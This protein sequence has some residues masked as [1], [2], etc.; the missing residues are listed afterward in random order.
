MEHHD[1]IKNIKKWIKNRLDMTLSTAWTWS[2]KTLF[3]RSSSCSD[4]RLHNSIFVLQDSSVLLFGC[5]NDSGMRQTYTYGSGSREESKKETRRRT[6]HRLQ[7]TVCMSE[8]F[9]PQFQCE[10]EV[11]GR[12]DFT[13]YYWRWY[14]LLCETA[15]RKTYKCTNMSCILARRFTEGHSVYN[16]K[17]HIFVLSITSY[18]GKVEGAGMVEHVP[19]FCTLSAGRSVDRLRP[20]CSSVCTLD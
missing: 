14:M 20:T 9:L 3:R 17:G 12:A 8:S 1:N 5:L 10:M 16:N 13:G 18:S 4:I 2:H 6:L 15:I 11:S 19:C 7:T